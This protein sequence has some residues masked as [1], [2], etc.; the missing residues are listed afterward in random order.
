MYA[1]MNACIEQ[2]LPGANG[3]VSCG[4]GVSDARAFLNLRPGTT[5]G[6]MGRAVL[7]GIAREL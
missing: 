3:V 5:A 2:S 4:F 1:L 7:E 6:D